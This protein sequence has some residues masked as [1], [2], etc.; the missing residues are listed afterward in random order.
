MH[1]DLELARSAAYWACQP[2]TDRI[3]AAAISADLSRQVVEGAA[4]VH[5]GMGFTWELGL[6]FRTRHI[7]V[8]RKLITGIQ[9][10]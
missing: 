7:L 8:V 4:Q 5:G 6:H 10:A 1:R 2:V 9:S 3:R